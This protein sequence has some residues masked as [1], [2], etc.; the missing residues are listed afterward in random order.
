[1]HISVVSYHIAGFM[2]GIGVY[3]VCIILLSV[4]RLCFSMSLFYMLYIH[5]DLLYAQLKV[6]FLVSMEMN[7]A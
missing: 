7:S 1:M 6:L 2:N 4:Y 3:C 5:A